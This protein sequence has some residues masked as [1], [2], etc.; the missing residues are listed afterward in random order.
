LRRRGYVE[1]TDFTLESHLAEGRPD[2]LPDLAAGLVASR[3]DLI[4]V[5]GDQAIREVKAQTQAIPVVMV[6]C[7]AVAA[8]IIDSLARPGG[9]ITGTTCIS[10]VV[11]A[12]RLELLKEAVPGLAEAALLW[13]AG[14]RGKAVEADETR[15]AAEQLGLRVLPLPVRGPDDLPPAFEA[16]TRGGADGLVVLGEALTLAHRR[17]IADFAAGARLPAMYTF[18]EF[19]AADGLMSYGTDLPGRFRYV[20]SYADKI[21]KGARPADLPVEQPTEFEFVINLKAAGALG[22]TIPESALRQATELIQ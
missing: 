6:S 22:L 12:K 7:D 9:N 8:G 1:G 18:R 2:R 10:A 19:V 17:P 14:D 3:P 16:A 4:L 11:S 15:A 20:A 21:L 13:N 5:S